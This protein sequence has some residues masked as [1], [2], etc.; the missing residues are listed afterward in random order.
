[1]CATQVT[2]AASQT[3]QRRNVKLCSSTDNE[4]GIQISRIGDMYLVSNPR[5]Q[6][7]RFAR[8]IRRDLP[9]SNVMVSTGFRGYTF[10]EK[11]R[12]DAKGRRRSINLLKQ[13]GSD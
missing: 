9:N 6:N 5:Q 3:T 1:L 13:F 4:T 12:F 8:H 11:C 10:N 2:Q 7:N